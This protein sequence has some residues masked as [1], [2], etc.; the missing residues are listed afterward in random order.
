M[1]EDTPQPRYEPRIRKPGN[2]NSE[3]KGHRRGV[4]SRPGTSKRSARTIRARQRQQ[5]VL[6]LRL[7]GLSYPKIAEAVHVSSSQV[8]RDLIAAMADITREPA[9]AVFRMEMERLDAMTTA[10]F[11]PACQGNIAS[12]HALL[13]IMEHRSRLMG[14]DKSDGMAAKLTISDGANRKLE[15]EFVLPNG[16]RQAIDAPPSP[17][18]SVRPIQHDQHGQRDQQPKPQR[19]QPLDSDITLERCVPSAWKRQHGSYDWLK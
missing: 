1:A 10:H 3:W 5:Q 18:Q 12:T 13:R 11:V 19:I 15:V 4:A 2:K 17:Q 7:A 8:E 6:Q 14:W 16:T 9:E